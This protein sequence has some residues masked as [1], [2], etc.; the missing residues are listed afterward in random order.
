MQIGRH[1][2]WV[3]WGDVDAA[4]IV[5]YPKYFHWFDNSTNL[6]FEQVGLPVTTLADRFGIFAIPIVDTGA[7]FLLPSRFGDR[8]IV[9]SHVSHWS[10]KSFRVSHKVLKG[11]QVAVEGH[12]VRV[13]ASHHPDDPERFIT[14]PIPQEAKDLFNR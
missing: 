2:V 11:D 7:R 8:F 5:Y 12:E 4:S 13:W 14:T 3:G 9:E 6:L 10:T 1:E